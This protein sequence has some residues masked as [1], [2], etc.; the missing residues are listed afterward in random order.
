[1]ISRCPNPPD[2]SPGTY[3]RTIALI[4]GA[5]LLLH[6]G[7]MLAGFYRVEADESARSL[8]AWE[9]SW[10]NAL[11]PWIWPPFYKIV[12]G[13]FLDAYADVFV[14][15]R[16]LV[17]LAGAATVAVLAGLALAL[18]RDRL[19]AV[20]AAALAVVVPDQLIPGTVPL[21][22]IYYFLAMVGASLC[23]LR[24]LQEGRT[25]R[26]LLGCVLIAIAETVRFEA[27]FFGLV[28]GLFLVWRLLVSRGIGP[29][30]FAAAGALLGGFPLFWVVDSWLWYGSL[31]NLGITGQQ[32]LAIYGP[33]YGRAARE[34]PAVHLLRGLAW[35][36]PL[37]LGFAA[38]LWHARLD[39]AVRRWVWLLWLPLPLISLVILATLSITQAAS[40]RTA[41]LWIL[42]MVPFEAWAL[43]RLAA[44]LGRDASRRRVLSLLL[45]AALV[46]PVLR[47]AKL[48]RSGMFNWESGHRREERPLGLQLRE[49]LR[50]LG[51]GRVLLDS[52]D[53]YDYLDVLTGS[54]APDRFVLTA[55]APP[56][57]V[58]LH[59]PMLEYYRRRH[60]EADIARYLSDRFNLAQGGDATAFREHDIRLILVRRPEFVAGL[61]ASPLVRR[62]RRFADWT[63]Y[64]VRP[65]AL[66]T[67]RGATP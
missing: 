53:N 25:S 7:L 44:R 43:V 35:N 16:I 66:Q 64:R 36:P 17:A 3:R 47:S 42:L 20:V 45:A 28:L 15:P 21:S 9:L 6:L 12:V 61:D 1:M 49:E 52:L 56:L 41:G 48:V 13:L 24:W 54:S 8:L 58:A 34:L 62:E 2:M 23:L 32:Y 50:R 27:I 30:A 67:T 46:P 60:D 65:E 29:G 18:F 33:D 37:L 40:W 10:R 51:G 5:A 19:T 63:L 14:G 38:M 4:A 26:L 59:L 55:D 11:E 57:E 39:P 31:E 22:D